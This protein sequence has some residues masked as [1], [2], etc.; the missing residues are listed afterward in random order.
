MQ[1]GDDHWHDDT[2][3]YGY[4]GYILFQEITCFSDGTW[5]IEV[6]YIFPVILKLLF[7]VR[8]NKT[9]LSGNI[10][11]YDKMCEVPGHVYNQLYFIPLG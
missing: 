6:V 9:W 8:C 3:F 7:K 5:Q 4:Y 10:S 2:V 1:Q 11:N